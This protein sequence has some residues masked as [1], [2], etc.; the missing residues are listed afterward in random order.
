M[1]YHS[2]GSSVYHIYQKCSVGNNI[3]KGNKK[4]G[5]GG[6]KLCK[7]CKEIKAGKRTR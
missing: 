7:T 2:K 4:T 5:S 6:K 3:E 1:A